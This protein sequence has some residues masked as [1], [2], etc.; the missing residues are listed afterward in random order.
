MTILPLR[1]L[2]DER[3]KSGL[4]N[5]MLTGFLVPVFLVMF[6]L[7][8]SLEAQHIYVRSIAEDVGG[9]VVSD[10]GKTTYE[11]PAGWRLIG[12]RT[13]MKTLA[14][15]PVLCEH[16]PR[17]EDSGFAFL[18][19]DGRWEEL[20][21]YNTARDLGN[22]C[23][24]L[25]RKDSQNNTLWCPHGQV[26]LERTKIHVRFSDKGLVV[27]RLH[28]EEGK[29]REGLMT[30]EG[31][32]VFPPVATKLANMGHDRYYFRDT[33]QRIYLLRI[34]YQNASLQV[35][36]IIDQAAQS[37]ELR[38]TWPFDITG[39]SWAI[40]G[41]R[42]MVVIDTSGTVKS[43]TLPLPYGRV[44]AFQNGYGNV[45][46]PQQ[47]V[48]TKGQSIQKGNWR[49]ALA[50]E[51]DRM[52]V[53][54]TISGFLGYLD[55]YG[56]W[57][58]PPQYCYASSFRDG[59]AAVDSSK[60]AHCLNNTRQRS[61][62]GA[63]P[64]LLTKRSGWGYFELIDTTGKVV[65]QDSCRE[66]F[67]LPGRVIGRNQSV[68]T[69]VPATRID[70][71]SSGDYWLSPDYH[72]SDWEEARNA[73]ADEVL[74]VDIGTHRYQLGL[75]GYRYSLP[76]DFAEAL[77]EWPQLQK[78][79]LDYHQVG[80]AWEAIG[81][82]EALERLSVARCSLAVLPGR[83]GRL[84]QLTHLDLSS[85]DLEEL[86]NSLY[87]MRQLEELNVADN[88]LPPETIVRLRKRLPT[89]KI[90]YKREW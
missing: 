27:A 2:S 40:V 41:E 3:Q 23:F 72:F 20:T 30:T 29:H 24:A 37:W 87:Q 1:L 73:P 45:G 22:A 43:D 34:L 82:L 53:Q 11:L 64:A 57:A 6:L 12:N 38:S 36:T 33:L 5:K 15:W 58:I 35:D 26:E 84:R 54:D 75:S 89:T 14:D 85:N 77:A 70:W 48:D 50:P 90:I 63:N 19:E 74:R 78:L 13:A 44:R 18:H 80:E 55:S 76:S 65:L 68:G 71:L 28:T 83:I 56:E 42:Q 51:D 17:R 8:E 62:S 49:F 31:Q 61:K 60:P 39:H 9:W 21:E 79:K 4:M 25:G 67:L 16:F 59:L 66:L 47:W 81:E 86:P 69:S 7:A 88:P 46:A 32:W 10:K 52:L